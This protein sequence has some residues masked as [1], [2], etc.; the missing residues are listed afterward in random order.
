MADR[1]GGLWWYRA[2]FVLIAAFVVFLHLLPLHPGPGQLPGPDVL[3]LLV[4]SWTIMRPELVPVLL[5]AAVFLVCDL[6]IMRPPG[7][8]T[9]LTVL[10]CEFLRSRRILLR[11][12]SFPV[13]WLL[14]TGVVAGMTVANALILSLFA[15]PQPAFGLTVIRMLFTIAVYPLVLVLAGRALGLSKPKGESESLGARR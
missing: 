6:L 5:V 11:N 7:L 10:G 13:E 3:L 12:A 15:V 4:L 8:W 1:I 14:V 2:L 9:A